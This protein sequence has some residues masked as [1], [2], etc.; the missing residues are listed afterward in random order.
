MGKSSKLPRKSP[1]Q[2]RSKAL[3]DAIFEATVRVLPKVGSAAITTKQIAE[4]AGISVG[5]LYQYFPDKKAIL[6]AVMDATMSAS[7]S[8][9]ERKIAGLDNLT[10]EQAIDELVALTLEVCLSDRPQFREIHSKAIELDRLP[11]LLEQ[12]RKVVSTIAKLFEK[13]RPGFLES[14]YQS[15]SFVSTNAVMGV[16]Q[17]MLFD[18]TTLYSKENLGSE[19]KLLLNAYL[20]SRFGQVARK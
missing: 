15:A 8:S 13:H 14:D 20:N 19:L 10:L 6:T 4:V 17:T 11:V 1:K 5:S 9:F 16:I 3:V 7:M 18:S 12:R 2:G